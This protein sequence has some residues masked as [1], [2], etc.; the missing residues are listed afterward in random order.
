M[1]MYKYISNGNRISN[2]ITMKTRF[3][4]ESGKQCLTGKRTSKEI[5]S[6]KGYLAKKH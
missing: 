1:I 2:R 4:T 3:N 5:D 6:R